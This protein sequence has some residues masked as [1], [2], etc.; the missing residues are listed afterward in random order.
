MVEQEQ[1]E[2]KPQTQPSFEQRSGLRELFELFSLTGFVYG[3]LDERLDIRD[4][5][6]KNLKKP[7]PHHVNWL[8]CFGGIS[9]FL[10]VVQGVTGIMLLMYYRP[11]VAEAYK[12]VVFITNNVPFGWLVRGLHHWAANL[13]IIMVF[14]H[15]A[16]VFFYG[17]YKP[18][19]DFNWVTGVIL[20]TL[21]LGFGF[22]GYLLPWS[23]ISYWA[24]TVGTEVPA[25][26]PFIGGFL[27]TLIRGG[28]AVGQS[29]L[30]RFFAVHVVILPLVISFFLLGHFFMIRKQGIS[31]PL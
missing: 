31:G 26:V 29:T 23:Q 12:S 2:T 22:T 16:R 21:T 18:P 13:M 17:A 20:L 5:L 30:T 4:A 1:K 14:L 11:T 25:A 15:M 8:F 10:F 28:Q 9:L 27:S 7:V 3:P 24:T 19:R 6:E